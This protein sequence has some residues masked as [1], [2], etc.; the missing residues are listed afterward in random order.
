MQNLPATRRD[1]LPGIGEKESRGGA[2]P[3]RIGGRKVTADIPGGQ[4]PQYRVGQ[5]VQG[6]IGIGMP[7]QAPVMGNLHAAERDAVSLPEAM[8][9]ETLAD[10]CFP[11]RGKA[12]LGG[13]QV[14]P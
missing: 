9:V 8:Y 10:A 13:R 6:H 3:L 5:R 14:F 7:E 12:Q 11:G 4:R 2:P 1:E